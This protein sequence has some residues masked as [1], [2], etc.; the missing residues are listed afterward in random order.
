MAEVGL[1]NYQPFD[2]PGNVVRLLTMFSGQFSDDIYL[3]IVHDR[4]E[5]E[6]PAVYEFISYV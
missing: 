3:S 1:F 5:V 6:N 2:P 4:L